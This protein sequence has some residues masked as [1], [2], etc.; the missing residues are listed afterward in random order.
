M[1]LI[2]L[3][4][5]SR[6][7]QD[8]VLELNKLSCDGENSKDDPSAK[9]DISLIEALLLENELCGIGDMQLAISGEQVTQSASTMGIESSRCG[10]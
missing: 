10:T 1:P 3:R 4:F 5:F 6:L 9:E 2:L 7:S 8:V